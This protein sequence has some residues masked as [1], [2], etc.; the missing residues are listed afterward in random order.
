M[1]PPTDMKRGYLLRLYLLI[2]Y[3]FPLVAPRLLRRRL[4]RGKETPARWT[5]KLG[6]SLGPRPDGPLIWLHG[7]GLGEV[8]SLRGLITRLA[9]ARPDASFLVT[10]TTAASAQVFAKNLPPRTLHQFLPIDAPP[11]RRRFLDHFRPDL[12]V[13]AEQDIWPGF[14]SDAARRGIPQAV[15]AARMNA[16]SHRAHHR[17]RSLYRD[18]YRAMARVTAQDSA[19]AGHLTQLGARGPV[20]ITGSLKPGAV[21]LACD[22]AELHLIA[23]AFAG[24]TVWAVAPSHR[25]DEDIALAAHDLLRQT[26]PTALLI[27]APRFPDRR[28][29]IAAACHLPLKR[30]SRGELPDIDDAIWLCDTFGDLGLIYRLTPTVLI[31]GTFDNTAGHN[32][33]EAAALHTA[34]LHGPCVGNF[35]TDFAMLDDVNAARR[36]NDAPQLAQAVQS[37][38]SLAHNATQVIAAASTQTDTLARDLLKLLGSAHG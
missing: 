9:D 35:A 16:K 25:A 11:Y 5:E 6:Q 30:R 15:I 17:A 26:D 27:I 4:A 33:W 19:T 14:V 32:P 20:A 2:S 24:R 29:A 23:G 13:W 12:C 8:L 22:C 18:L 10:S 38:G 7:V 31:G 3:A 37:P 36:V 1:T 21:P 28:D 34:I